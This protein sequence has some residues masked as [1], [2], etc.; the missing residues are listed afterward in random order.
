LR[1]KKSF[2]KKTFAAKKR[3]NTHAK[4]QREEFKERNTLLKTFASSRLCEEKN[5]S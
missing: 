1:G 3:R 2:L 5:L 4:P